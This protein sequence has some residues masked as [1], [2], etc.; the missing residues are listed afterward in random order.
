MNV[1]DWTM[2]PPSKPASS[3]PTSGKRDSLS[4]QGAAPAL[5]QGV[6][7]GPKRKREDEDQQQCQGKRP[8]LTSKQDEEGAAAAAVM[9]ADPDQR[10]A[11]E[12][13]DSLRTGG[14]PRQHGKEEEATTNHNDGQRMQ[15]HQ[16][17]QSHE[18]R[19]V[20]GGREDGRGTAKSEGENGQSS[21]NQS[22]FEG[23]NVTAG[24]EAFLLRL[25]GGLE[26]SRAGLLGP[27]GNVINT[28][29][30]FGGASGISLGAMASHAPST[31]NAAA[32][33]ARAWDVGAIMANNGATGLTPLFSGAIGAGAGA[34][35][36]NNM[37]WL[38]SPGVQQIINNF[39]GRSEAPGDGGSYFS[40]APN[41]SAH[42]SA[43]PHAAAMDA[44]QNGA[45][46]PPPQQINSLALERA[47]GDVK[48]PFYLPPHL[49][50][51]CY[52]ITH[53]ALP[54]LTRLSMLALHSQQNLLKHFPILHEPTFRLDTTPGCL[55]FA[56]CM[57]GNHQVGRMWWAGEEVVPKK[58]PSAW[59][60]ATPKDEPM[61][62][63]NADE[64]SKNGLFEKR[65]DEVR[66]D[67][68]DG[69]ELVR[70]IVMTEKVDMLIRSFASRAKSTKDKVFVVEALMLFQSNNFLS[71]DPATRSVA[72]LSHSSVVNL[73]RKAGL[74]DVDAPHAQRFV[75][76]TPDDVV[77]STIFEANDLCFSFSF[78]PNYLP[79]C[80]DEE[81]L[82]RRWSD[83][84]GRRRTAFMILIMDTVASLDAGLPVQ[85]GFDEVVH[86]PLPSPDTVWRAPNSET[87]RKN[88]E[89][90]RGPTFDEAMS[91]LLA[92]RQSD[93]EALAQS[94]D[95]DASTRA[96][97]VFG[98]HGPFARLVMVIALLRGIIHL[99]EGRSKR[100]PKESPVETWL[101]KAGL[102]P[103][104]TSN[105]P[106]LSKLDRDAHIFRRALARWRKAWDHDNLCLGASG[107]TGQLKAAKL[108]VS[109]PGTHHLF[110]SRTASG[111]TPLSDDALPFF[112]L[113][114]VLLVHGSSNHALSHD[115]DL[116]PPN[117]TIESPATASLTPEQKRAGKLPDFKRMLR[118]A[119]NFVDRDED[120]YLDGRINGGSIS[121][122]MREFAMAKAAMAQT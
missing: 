1:F 90:Y 57:L 94:T 96:P 63:D 74:F 76:Y 81:K 83:Y 113:A 115:S 45:P 38:L 91:D 56:M 46:S 105:R 3:N 37:S 62:R 33:S 111:A 70:P 86:L 61:Y 108:S 31:T 21:G 27:D 19:T 4:Q 16:Q 7:P 88:L 34:A 121:D 109:E 14:T 98:G 95:K 8:S 12:L 71:S 66:Y 44:G 73:A 25:Q 58:G 6:G 41:G 69:Q 112:W 93:D 9:A 72:A 53:W 114:Q 18:S 100:V 118:V 28:E 103:S 17:Q 47:L 40:G 85:I 35:G 67:E 106:P 42:E 122:E 20:E 104:V 75:T 117:S 59:S 48:N 87:W 36:S 110:A 78:L 24:P 92:P 50:R 11:A 65:E 43:L 52:S 2:R 60:I 49:F 32:M 39:T 55:A 64:L 68:E 99:L 29:A 13:L 15:Q 116:T 80:P 97:T 89:R 26:E 107:H 120:V 84:A 10:T 22:F 5:P 79:S 119:K 54:S 51:S 77:R 101:A 23:R 30:P 82:W 102:A